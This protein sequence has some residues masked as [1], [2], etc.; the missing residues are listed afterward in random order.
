EPQLAQLQADCGLTHWYD[1][2]PAQPPQQRVLECMKRAQQEHDLKPE[3]ERGLAPAAAVH[4]LAACAVPLQG[5]FANSYDVAGLSMLA[6]VLEP[7]RSLS[8]LMTL[9]ADLGELARDRTLGRDVGDRILKVG[10]ER[11]FAATELP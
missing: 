1:T 8:P 11:M 6:R 2:D 7:L 3:H 9:L 5:A 10:V 4:E